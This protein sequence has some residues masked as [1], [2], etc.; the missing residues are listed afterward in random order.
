MGSTSFD[1]ILGVNKWAQ[2]H[3]VTAHIQG[4]FV[5][6][7]QSAEHITSMYYISHFISQLCKTCA[8]TVALFFFFLTDVQIEGQGLHM[9]K[10]CNE[11]ITSDR[12]D[13]E[14]Q[15]LNCQA[16][17]LLI[18]TL[19]IPRSMFPVLCI[20]RRQLNQN[21]LG[22]GKTSG[23]EESSLTEKIWCTLDN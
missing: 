7:R 3:P 21:D 18:R 8:N 20:Q 9:S 13:S 5:M 10:N 12:S 23:K 19:L 15:A 4:G 16:A 1:G 6:C 17:L 2:R 14:V 11:D 22:S